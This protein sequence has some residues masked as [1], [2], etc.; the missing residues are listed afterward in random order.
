MSRP[1]LASRLGAWLTHAYAESGPAGDR[2]IRCIGYEFRKSV[3]SSP[4][5][6]S[7][8]SDANE[9]NRNGMRSVE[10]LCVD[11]KTAESTEN[12]QTKSKYFQRKSLNEKG[13]IVNHDLSVPA[14]YLMRSLISS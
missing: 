12:S 11:L 8:E 6:W 13:E 14:C 5:V 10:D 1:A 4:H 9:F 7:Q 3:I 2:G